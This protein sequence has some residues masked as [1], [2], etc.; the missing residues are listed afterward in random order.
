MRLLEVWNSGIAFLINRRTL[1]V[2]WNL[3][4]SMLAQWQ[5]CFLQVSGRKVGCLWRLSLEFVTLCKIMVW[6]LTLNVY[7]LCAKLDFNIISLADGISHLAC[8]IVF[9]SLFVLCFSPPS[10]YFIFSLLNFFLLF[11]EVPDRT[12]SNNV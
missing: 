3:S 9:P 11:H 12:L 10:L 6:R 7:I 2:V 1:T 5:L 8:T 4:S